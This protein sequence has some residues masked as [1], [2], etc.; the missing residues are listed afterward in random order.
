VDVPRDDRTE[1]LLV[2]SRALHQA[3]L[4]SDALE[5]AVRDL[6]IS[7]GLAIQINAL[8]TTL[9]LAVGPPFAQQLVVLRL[10]PGK[11]N[12]R[13]LALLETL[14]VELRKGLEPGLALAEVVQIDAV[15]PPEP[16]WQTVTAYALL[17]CGASLLLG[18]AR[19][20]VIV[21][22]IGG[23]AI[24]TIAALARRYR[25]ID[26]VFELAA[27]FVITIIVAVWE[28]FGSPISLYVTL[29]AGIVQLLPGY[30]LTTA[31][32]ELA[33]RNLVSGTSRLGGVLV[34]L[35]SLGSGFA[36][37]AGLAGN[38]ILNAPTV[39][40]G[41]TTLGS[42]TAA[43]VLMAIAIASILS[44]RYRDIGWIVASCVG[45]VFLAH[46]FPAVG[47]VQASPFAT[48]F[49]IGLVTDLAARYLRFPQSVVLVPA[50]LV[51]VPGSISYES[52]LYVFQADQT[53]AVSLGIRALLAAILIVSGFLTSQLVAPPARRELG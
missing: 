46:L 34:T 6:A 19:D 48:A 39:S 7:L 23:V 2:L 40:P 44:A 30:S 5:D 38:A 41:H 25:R 51:L 45:T 27:A 10:E 21:S 3:G 28:R 18:G 9:T 24:G 36:L 49:T 20:E 26:R 16:P 42:T 33:N 53:D 1:L 43:A 22:T 8:P 32:H 17:S 47:I 12:L 50:L 29:I 52:L 31:L 14:I 15:V 11:L 35:L 37:G 4:A 13:K